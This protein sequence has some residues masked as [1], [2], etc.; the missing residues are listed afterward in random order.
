MK[1]N[2]LSLLLHPVTALQYLLRRIPPRYFFQT[3]IEL[4]AVRRPQYAYG[5]SR[6][7]WQA[8][9]LGINNITAIEF[10]VA[11]GHGLLLIE[12]YAQLITNLTGVD[13][14]VIGFDL[15]E[16]LPEPADFRD[17]PYIW[18]KGFFKMDREALERK[19]SPSTSLF[20]GDVS[21]TVPEF[22]KC[23]FS[24]IGFVA[25]DM[26]F[27]SST[28]ES[29]RLFEDSHDKFLP[30]VYC[31]FDDII[32]P[33][34]ELM[35]SYV[36]ELLAI[37]EFNAAHKNMKFSLINGLKYKRI[38]QAAWNDMIYVLHRFDHPLYNEY[39]YPENK[40]QTLL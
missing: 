28:I 40:R 27:Y 18:K 36:G 34:E 25:F 20:L 21:E 3:R 16:G 24:P 17:M 19:L 29:F 7:A 5:L 10:G 23:G 31:Y 11:A 1:Y 2:Y 14:D 13:I 22:Q 39:I 37:Q 35:N 12:K 33:D 6:A 26:D 9:A 32:G 4:D 38:F 8:K 15:E 30:R